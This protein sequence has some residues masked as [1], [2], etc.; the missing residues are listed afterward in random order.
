VLGQA[1]PLWVWNLE[2]QGQCCVVTTDFLWGCG[3]ERDAL[4]RF[5]ERFGSILP[6]KLGAVLV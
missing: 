6:E 3:S 4:K 2:E 5:E 1:L